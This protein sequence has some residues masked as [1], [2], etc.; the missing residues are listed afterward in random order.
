MIVIV[1]DPLAVIMLLASQ[2]TFGWSREQK[3]NKPETKT[4]FEAVRD[5]DSG[6]WIQTGPEFEYE[7]PAELTD[8]QIE[9]INRML[10][11]YAEP[12]PEPEVPEVEEPAEEEH[13]FRGRGLQPSIPM[14][15]SYI[16]PNIADDSSKESIQE[17]PV[18]ITRIAV[19]ESKVDLQVTAESTPTSPPVNREAA[20]ARGRGVMHTH[21]A[22]ADNG[23]ITGRP[24]G[25]GF[26]NEFPGNPQ[27]GDVYLRVD[28]LPNRL[29]KFNGNKWIEVDKESTDVYAYEEEYIKHLVDEID[30][31]RYDPDTLT[32]V[33]REQIRQFLEKNS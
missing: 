27:K 13:P 24:S 17:A 18:L 23:P 1:F 30:A 14:M 25:T 21:L 19:P 31:G 20:P 8:E 26:G 4:A 15:P 2:M 5:P 33:E 10:A 3:E 28:Y 16:Q 22:S 6:E 32:D 12:V 9:A 11:E 7:V 29:F